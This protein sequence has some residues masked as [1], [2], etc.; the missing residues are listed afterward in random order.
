MP[1]EILGRQGAAIHFEAPGEIPLGQGRPL[2]RESE[3]IWKRKAEKDRWTAKKHVDSGKAAA[4]RPPMDQ[5]PYAKAKVQRIV[6]QCAR[7]EE[8]P[9]RIKTEAWLRYI[10]ITMGGSLFHHRVE[11][12]KESRF[13]PP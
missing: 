10:R 8:K 5:L 12:C 13:V 3:P 11:E 4:V 2:P 9:E 6:C 7:W 1:S